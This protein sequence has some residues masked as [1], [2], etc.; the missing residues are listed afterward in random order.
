MG[1][2][3][4]T[5]EK[6]WGTKAYDPSKHSDEPVVFCGLYG[7]PDWY[8]LW[9]H[10]GKKYVWW[11]G[12]DI[13]H[14]NNGYWLDTKGH[15]R[16]EPSPFAQWIQENCESW[17]ENSVEAERLADW[18]I[19]AKV[20]PSWM[21]PE[22]KESYEWRERPQVYLSVSGDNFEQYGWY[23]IERIAGK[24]N[25]DFHL[26][27][28]KKRWKTR[29]QNVHIHGRV[30]KEVMNKEVAKMQCGLRPLEHDGFSEVL[31]KSVLMAQHPISRIKYPHIKHYETDGQL[32]ALLNNLVWERNPN[33]KA[34][35][36]YLKTL[37]HYPWAVKSQ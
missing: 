25:V 26:Y 7:L 1:A 35:R 17:C 6:V 10:K 19:K 23:D 31:A 5:P 33:R 37:N 12:T 21:G 9:R 16:V 15:I 32:I 36:H 22:V 14:F 28:N 4:S 34:R 29:H 13:T 24:C 18:G 30:S 11:T 2:L 3:E 8:A 20:C 27:G